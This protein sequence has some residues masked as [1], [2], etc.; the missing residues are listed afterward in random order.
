ME[1]NVH[2]CSVSVPPVFGSGLVMANISQAVILN[3]LKA[4]IFR[5]LYVNLKRP[6]SLVRKG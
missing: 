3:I 2:V 4:Y 6:A 1:A 5:C